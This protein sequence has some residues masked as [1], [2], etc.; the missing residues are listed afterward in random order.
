MIETVSR[1]KSRTSDSI[2]LVAFGSSNT[3]LSLAL[4]G[5]H[6]WVS[7][8]SVAITAQVGHH[9]CV[10]NRGIGGETT[11]ELLGRI[12]R[13]VLSFAPE[14]VIVTIGGNDAMRGMT[15]VQ[16]KDNLQ[17][18]CI[19]IKEAGA[20]PVLQ[21]YYC[22]LYHQMPAGFAA[23]FEQFVQ[24][25]RDIADLAGYGLIDQ[26]RI[27]SPLYKADPASYVSLMR[28]SFHLNHIGNLI[29]AQQTLKALGLA[30]VPVPGDW[31]EASALPADI[32]AL[33]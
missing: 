1:W 9:V 14:L 24:A 25:N 12:E 2:R 16:Y 18:L 22:P 28:D 3:E 30:R 11:A 5:R 23:L 17:K 21:T 19:L 13:D 6:N 15:V 10:I 32:R 31:T 33:L 27:F 7:W 8:L 20:Q 29:M 26:Y 4:A